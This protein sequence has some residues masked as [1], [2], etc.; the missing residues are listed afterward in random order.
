MVAVLF[1][2]KNGFH[3]VDKVEVFAGSEFQRDEGKGLESLMYCLL[4]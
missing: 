2:A 4:Y 1:Y 3:K